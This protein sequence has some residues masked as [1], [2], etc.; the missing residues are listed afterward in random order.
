MKTRKPNCGA[1]LITRTR[2]PIAIFGS[3]QAI[4]TPERSVASGSSPGGASRRRP[5]G[6]RTP[7]SAMRPPTS[8]SPSDSQSVA[9]GPTRGTAT[10]ARSDPRVGNPPEKA[11][12]NQ[13]TAVPSRAGGGG[14]G[15]PHEEPEGEERIAEPAQGIEQEDHRIVIGGDPEPQERHLEDG[16]E[17]QAGRHDPAGS[18]EVG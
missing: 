17:A 10:L 3:F 6:S 12:Q 5:V 2:Q 7:S 14:R 9:Y 11:N 4:V 8:T 15:V 18:P 13:P 16:P 1:V